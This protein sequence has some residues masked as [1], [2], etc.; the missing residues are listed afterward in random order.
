M[1]FINVDELVGEIN[2]IVNT[3]KEDDKKLESTYN[4]IQDVMN[5]DNVLKGE[6]GNAIKDHLNTLHIPVII[7]FRQFITRY[8]NDLQNILS[9]IQAFEN[10]SGFIRQDFIETI[11]KPSLNR[12]KSVTVDIV[13]NINA[14]ISSI[15]DL[16]A[17]TR[18][19]SSMFESAI[20]N[21]KR[22]AS[23]TI[24]ELNSLDKTVTNLIRE[25]ETLLNELNQLVKKIKTWTENGIH[26][27]E[28]E[29]K[30]IEEYFLESD[31]IQKMV[32][33]SEEL[34][35]T[36]GDSTFQGQIGNWL[37]FAGKFNGGL[38]LVK[39]AI[40]TI[41]LTTGMLEM[42][43]DGKGN[44]IIRASDGWKK[45]NG[46]YGSKIAEKVYKF[47]DKGDPN[48]SNTIQKLLAKYNHKPAGVLKELIGLAPG[49]TRISFGTLVARNISELIEFDEV[50]IKNYEIKVDSKKTIENLENNFLKA[51]KK[52]PVA[53]L[54]FS[55]ITNSAEYIKDENT[56][57]KISEKTGRFVAG[58]ALDG[59][60][61]A[62]TTAGA[63][64]GSFFG[65][66]P[67]TIIGGLIGTGVGI[68][69]SWSFEDYIKDIGED[70]GRYIGEQ[71]SNVREDIDDFM[72][73]VEKSLANVG[74]F[75]SGL[76][77]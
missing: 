6:I 48:A 25:N 77:N 43:E 63:T 46:V 60:T 69:V 56:N 65:P 30:E 58:I 14:E 22:Y 53:G 42:V 17:P 27:G 71:L 37:D 66:G 40:G 3:K 47:L 9:Q 31:I 8:M 36:E 13:D 62:F 49:T 15:S 24:E 29:I 23:E 76:F 34:V 21:A 28:K 41:I 10:D 74:N 44:F 55:G 35:E 11:V 18:V 45:V 70:I 52:I 57:L 73:S 16:I 26:L 19:N 4:V 39:Y 64:I 1:K 33:Q 68:I 59:S 54:I 67:G 38:D 50:A 20:E 7:I 51:A 12:L 2:R 75:I 72:N 61:V 32:E 5:L